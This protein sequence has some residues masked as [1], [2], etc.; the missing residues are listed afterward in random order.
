MKKVTAILFTSILAI[1]FLQAQNVLK[2]QSGAIIKT[3]GGALITLQN[4]NLDND[5]TISQSVG[6]GKFLFTGAADNT[7]SGTGTILFDVLEIGKTG[8]AKISLQQN[9]QVGSGVIFTSGLIDLNNSNIFLQP[10]CLLIGESETSRITG[11]TG[12]Y[13]EI[14]N[15]LNAPAAANPGNLGAM[16]TSAQNM[17]ITTIRRGHQSQTNGYGNGNTIYRYYDITPA[18]NTALNA[19][20]RLNYFDAELNS[21]NENTITLWKKIGASTWANQGFNTRNTSTN[22]VEK[23][24]I[25]D[26]S[27]WTL[28]TPLNPLP[29]S[30]GLF[31]T[32]CLNNAVKIS[33]QTFQESNTRSFA[34]QHT[35]D[36][37]N[38]NDL[39]T[40]PAAGNSSSTLYYTYTHL[41]SNSNTNYYRIIE[42]DIDGRKNYSPVLKSNCSTDKEIFFVYPNPAQNNLWVS[43]QTE[44]SG[45]VTLQMFDS[46]GALVKQ[47]TEN[48]QSGNNL[49][50]MQL[51]N[52]A[53]GIYSL[54]VRYGE[55]KV[56]VVKVDKL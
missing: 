52:L 9:I 28:T 47:Q 48:M 7:I 33:W 35:S 4:M 25:P 30:W 12:G 34:V 43:L 32:Q 3:T 39:T 20:L 27:R 11:T 19:T 2:V 15:T 13:I 51:N 55:G 14:T 31:N 29:L 16:I 24:A 38:W 22:Y 40:L 41:P 49:L 46:K 21:L 5:G 26:F 23:T 8:T 18:N 1:T 10:S 44:K 53:P 17:G 37:T 42:Q 6:E 50:G 54:V 45:K 56:K 36:G